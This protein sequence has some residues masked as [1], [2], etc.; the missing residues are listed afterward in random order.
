MVPDLR[1]A[2]TDDRGYMVVTLTP[3]QARADWIFVGSV[4]DN[5][6]K[7]HVGRSLLTRTGA[8][9]RRVEEV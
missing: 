7:S 9:G 8:G 6:L 5:T 1:Y 2:Q 4:F 3:T